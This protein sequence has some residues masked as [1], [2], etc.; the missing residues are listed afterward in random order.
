MTRCPSLVTATLNNGPR[1]IYRTNRLPN[2]RCGAVGGGGIFPPR[3]AY[4][5]HPIVPRGASNFV[6]N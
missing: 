2:G 1:N 6:V 5:T 3:A 4:F